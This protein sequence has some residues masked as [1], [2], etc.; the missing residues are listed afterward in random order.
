[1]SDE[2]HTEKEQ[3]TPLGAVVFRL[4]LV[5]SVIG[6]LVVHLPAYGHDFFQPAVLFF[7]LAIIVVDLIPVPVWGGMSLSLSFPILLGVSI[8]FPVPVAGSIALIGSVDPREIKGGVSPLTALFN[9]CQV[10]A[11]IIVGSALFHELATTDS[12][13]YVLIPAVL[14]TALAAY[15]V[16][17]LAVAIDHAIKNHVSLSRVIAKMHGTA[18]W[19]F[20]VSYVGLGLFG[21]AIARFYEDQG[22]WS[23]IVFLAPLVFARQ[24]YFRSRAL[25]DQLAERNKLLAE[26]ADRLEQLLAKEHDTVAELLEL[27]RMKGEFVAVVSHEL[28]TPVTALI[29]YAK[30]LQRRE[31]ADD[32]ALREEFLERMERQ[33]DRLLRLVENLLMA[34]RL[35][36]QEL[37]ISVQQVL[38]E[39]VCREVVEGL[40]GEGDRV[41]LQV[42]AD[43]P[44]LNTD[45][46]LLSRV[47]TNLIDNALK[48]SPDG[49]P[50]EL[51]ARP[52]DEAVE[53]WIRDEGVGIPQEQVDRIFERFYQV[54]SSSTRTFRGAGLGLALVAELLGHL[55]GRIDVESAPGEGSTFTVR[56]P[57]RHEFEQAET[58]PAA[59]EDDATAPEQVRSAG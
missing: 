39:D 34:S 44:V 9:R 10:G 19:E 25:A 3:R 20:V 49:A 11:S 51:G 50:V 38:F 33:G 57:V 6:W 52:Q 26:Q 35:E 5:G 29:G 48:Y 7:I 58:E 27:N 37:P 32:E 45:R 43:L 15:A 21:A 47:V 59:G 14:A 54:D 8:L 55:G 2:T 22:L 24:M 28:R 40:T 4:L 1:M 17:V 12:P 23:V 13:W 56:I 36:T 18:P 30:T 42:P 16:N 53:F 46:Q 41:D 31:F